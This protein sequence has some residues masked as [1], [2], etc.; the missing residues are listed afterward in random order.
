VLPAAVFAFLRQRGY[1]ISQ[2]AEALV[3]GSEFFYSLLAETS[4]LVS[5]VPAPSEPN[6]MG[7]LAHFIARVFLKARSLTFRYQPNP[8]N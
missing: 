8:P 7:G 4:H 1:A 3:D 6:E 2:S 5:F